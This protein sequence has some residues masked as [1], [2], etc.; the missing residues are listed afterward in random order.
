MRTLLS[1]PRKPKRPSRARTAHGTPDQCPQ[2]PAP[3]FRPT[4]EMWGAVLELARMRRAGR[5][6][7]PLDNRHGQVETPALVRVYVLPPGE[8]Q[9]TLR[10]WQLTEAGR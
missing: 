6:R 10:A 2:A 9:H 5:T 4:P 1:G 8:R 7:A 3:S